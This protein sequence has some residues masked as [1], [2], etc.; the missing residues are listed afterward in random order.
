MTI[1]PAPMNTAG[2]RRGNTFAVA[3]PATAPSPQAAS[4]VPNAW[5]PAPSVCVTKTSS[6]GT[7]A[8]SKTDTAPSAQKRRHRKCDLITNRAPA[9]ALANGPPSDAA[10][11]RGSRARRRQAAATAKLS[12]S[13]ARA[14]GAPKVAT[15]TPPSTGPIVATT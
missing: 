4:T 11:R 5:P 6:T 15:V 3:L 12:P 8:A 1:T 7:T 9:R 13:R 14:L 2:P 10:I